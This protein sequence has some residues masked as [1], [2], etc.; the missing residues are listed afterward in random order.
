MLVIRLRTSATCPRLPSRLSVK[1][2]PEKRKIFLGKQT[3]TKHRAR[4]TIRKQ[5]GACQLSPEKKVEYSRVLRRAFSPYPRG[6]NCLFSS[7]NVFCLRFDGVAAIEAMPATVTVLAARSASDEIFS[8]QLGPA[9]AVKMPEVVVFPVSHIPSVG[10]HCCPG[11]TR[12]VPAD[13]DLSSSSS[14]PILP[15]L[16]SNLTYAC[17]GGSGVC[18]MGLQYCTVSTRVTVI[19]AASRTRFSTSRLRLANSSSLNLSCSIAL[20]RFLTF[21]LGIVIASF[22]AFASGHNPA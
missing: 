20:M 19:C 2:S 11:V 6:S 4:S 12:P 16:F 18:E 15:S 10:G 14:R 13:D 5:Q 17:D 21:C 8:P 22:N 3:H 1:S 9:P 7:L